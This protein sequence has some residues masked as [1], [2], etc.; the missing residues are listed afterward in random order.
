MLGELVCYDFGSVF[1]IG[2]Y[3]CFEFFDLGIVRLVLFFGCV[4]VETVTVA[5]EC[6]E[7][8]LL[9]CHCSAL[10]MPP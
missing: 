3:R 8:V 5:F 4:G 9:F 10:L 7:D 6:S 2:E 1:Y